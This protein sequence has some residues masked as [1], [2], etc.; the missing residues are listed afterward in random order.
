MEKCVLV[1]VTAIN[2][3]KMASSALCGQDPG[4]LVYWPSQ[5]KALAVN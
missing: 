1:V 4:L 2:R 3:E 5:L